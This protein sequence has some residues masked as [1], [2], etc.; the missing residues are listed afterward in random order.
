ME[1]ET[2]TIMKACEVVG[3][4]RRTIYNW[5][6]AGKVE[7]VRTAG[8][9]IRIFADTLWR[10]SGHESPAARPAETPAGSHA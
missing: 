5:I 7:Y 3:V 6:S 4:S 10:S 2:L 9:S 8:G 1:R